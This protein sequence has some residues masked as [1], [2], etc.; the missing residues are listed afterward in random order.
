MN[1]ICPSLNLQSKILR[2]DENPVT[3][4]NPSSTKGI[5][6]HSISD[7]RTP[8]ASL[9]A[10]L[11]KTTMRA[12]L[13]DFM[14]NKL[15]CFWTVDEGT[16][17]LIIENYKDLTTNSTVDLVALDGGKWVKNISKVTFDKSDSPLSECV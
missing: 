16:Q 17:R 7:I 4:N 10:S 1:Q 13:L 15:N 5:Q 9:P 11:E 2:D 6:I 3:G 14:A 12:L 8:N